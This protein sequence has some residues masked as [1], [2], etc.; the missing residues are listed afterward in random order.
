VIARRESVDAAAAVAA[1][2]QQADRRGI[3]LPGKLRPPQDAGWAAGYARVAKDIP[4]IDERDLGSAIITV[5]RFI[6]PVLQGVAHGR[7]NPDR[8]GWT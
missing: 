2:R 1:L 8:T 7:W 6:D 3:S 4:D 5:S